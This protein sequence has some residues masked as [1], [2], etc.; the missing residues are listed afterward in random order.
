MARAPKIARYTGGVLVSACL[1]PPVGGLVAW[2]SMGAPA[3]RSPLPFLAGSWHE[4]GALALA[5]GAATAVGAWLGFARWIAPAG[6]AVLATAALAIAGA[7]ADWMAALHVARVF[8][9]PALV[10]ALACWLLTRKLFAP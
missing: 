4:G 8:L 7:G 9:P 6:A 10:A 3:L 2:L 1:G 5:V